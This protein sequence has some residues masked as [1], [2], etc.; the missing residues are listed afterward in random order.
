MDLYA[1]SG[2]PIAEQRQAML[3][4]LGMVRSMVPASDANAAAL[5]ARLDALAAYF[6]QWPDDPTRGA[7]EAQGEEGGDEGEGEDRADRKALRIGR[8]NRSITS[9]WTSTA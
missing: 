9:W 6:A 3:P 5:L 2:E 4:T 7:N 8:T 1:A